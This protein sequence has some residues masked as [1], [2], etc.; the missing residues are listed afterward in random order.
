LLTPVF[1]EDLSSITFA[2][3]KESIQAGYDAVMLN[4][5]QFAGFALSE[6]EYEA[7]V[8][9]LN[10]PRMQ[11]LPV[12]EFVRLENHSEIADSVVRRR[13]DNIDIGEPL[14]VD[15]VEQAMNKVYGLEYYQNVRYGLV[16]ADDGE[17]GLE[18]E[19]DPRSWG[20][21]YLQLGME[22][23]SAS[24]TDA[25]FSLAASYLRTAINDLGGE[26]RATF[27]IGDEPALIADLYQPFGDEAL[28]FIAPALDLGSDV[29]YAYDGDT[30]LTEAR[31]RES[32]AEF[33]VGRELPSWG[34]A[35]VGVRL[36]DGEVELRVGDPVLI[37]DDDY[38]RGEF[39]AR[40][41]VDTMDSVVFPRA[42]ILAG[43]EWRGSR[44]S[45]LSADVD[46]DQLSVSAAHAKTWG[47]H[48][49]LSTLRYDATISG[50]SPL[51]SRFTL[52]G[53]FDLSGLNENQLSGQHAMRIGGSYYRRIGDLALFPA[54]AGVSVELGNVWDQRSAMSFS[55][56]RLGGSFWAGVSTPV[57][58]V[59]VGI[60]RTEGGEGALYVSLG[61][62]F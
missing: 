57:G 41:A 16:T 45:A 3:I 20:P 18:V 36:A 13:L 59:Y 8:A 34:E 60:G 37:P 4:R 31:V 52:G 27:I 9:G 23:S 12:V 38:R 5:E 33:G 11:R 62:A 56:S 17:T 15:E 61:R 58:P 28:Y 44:Q 30:L 1:G 46:F 32:R 7:Y 39:F 19:L 47:R 54:F 42:G 40:F 24:D 25:L 51:N 2:R 10:D 35:R 50:A 14:D 43:I 49:V 6:V 21:N 26:W 55:D 53:F 29:V 22:Y 48:T